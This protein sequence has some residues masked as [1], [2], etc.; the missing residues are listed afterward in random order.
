MGKP[1][2][3]ISV[4]SNTQLRTSGSSMRT[5]TA[6]RDPSP[7]TLLPKLTTPCWTLLRTTALP[8][9]PLQL[10]RPFSI[11][12]QNI[13]EVMDLGRQ[14]TPHSSL[15]TMPLSTFIKNSGREPSSTLPQPATQTFGPSTQIPQ[16][17]EAHG[18]GNAIAWTLGNPVRG[19]SAC[20][21]QKVL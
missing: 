16:Q 17:S 8:E 21:N 7:Q 3:Q 1:K 6:G 5:Y 14:E 10:S 12:V 15:G 18:G 11:R 2:N 20:E 19:E 4:V 13:L 9:S